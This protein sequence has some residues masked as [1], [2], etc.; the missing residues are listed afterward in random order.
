MFLGICFI[1]L[2]R[3]YLFLMLFQAKMFIKLK[4]NL[5]WWAYSFPLDA[6]TIA[7]LLMYAEGGLF[8]F[9]IASYFMFIFLNLIIL[10]LVI[11]TII[12]NKE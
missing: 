11:K 10:I 1:I 9:K 6:L 3:F 7:T 4:F 2:V 12:A 5:P 8:F